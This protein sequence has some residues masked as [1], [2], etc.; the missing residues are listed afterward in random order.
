MAG[1]CGAGAGIGIRDCHCASIAATATVSTNGAA[2]ICSARAGATVGE[3]QR[4]TATQIRATV[5]AAA[6]DALG[7]DSRREVSRSDG[8]V[9]SCH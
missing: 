9:A 8:A 3:I 5:P 1:G 7:E 6:A 4:E 2:E